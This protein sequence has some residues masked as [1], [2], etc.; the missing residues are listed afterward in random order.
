[1]MT[2]TCNA[3]DSLVAKFNQQTDREDRVVGELEKLPNLSRLDVLKLSHIIMNDPM[4]IK[5]LFNLGEDLKVE[6]V[7]QLFQ[8]P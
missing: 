5:L 1:M 6:W 3:F 8:A 2:R 7:K 4:K